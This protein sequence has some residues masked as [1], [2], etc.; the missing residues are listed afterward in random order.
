MD[1]PDELNKVLDEMKQS[2]LCKKVKLEKVKREREQPSTSVPDQPPKECEQDP[3]PTKDDAEHKSNPRLAKMIEE[4]AQLVGQKGFYL[5]VG[6]ALLFAEDSNKDIAL[7]IHASGGEGG[8]W[9]GDLQHHICS[10]VPGIDVIGDQPIIQRNSPET[11]VLLSVNARFDTTQVHNHYMPGFFREQLTPKLYKELTE[12]KLQAEAI[13]IAH[14]QKEI[15]GMQAV[16]IGSFRDEAERRDH[17]QAMA[18]AQESL[19]VPLA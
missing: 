3:L 5:D 8:I 9:L 11:W 6:D 19:A 10:F 17:E 4:Y 15:E 14:L 13:Q 2:N 12:D 16:D 1:E 18:E 7:C